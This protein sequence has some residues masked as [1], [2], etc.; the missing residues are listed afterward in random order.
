MS[1]SAIPPNR[2]GSCPQ[3]WSSPTRNHQLPLRPLHRLSWTLHLHSPSVLCLCRL[4]TESPTTASGAK[5]WPK[6]LVDVGIHWTHMFWLNRVMP[7]PHKTPLGYQVEPV[8]KEQL[9][10]IEQLWRGRACWNKNIWWY[11][12]CIKTEDPMQ[13]ATPKTSWNSTHT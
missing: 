5:P 9:E 1:N 11:F 8:D 3:F 4:W 13:D 6:L 12:V 10:Q 7:N 2:V